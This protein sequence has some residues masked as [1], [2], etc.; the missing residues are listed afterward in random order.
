LTL[1]EQSE[2]CRGKSS[3]GVKKC[4]VVG[5]KNAVAVWD[6]EFLKWGP[7]SIVGGDR[8]KCMQAY[9]RDAEK[10]KIIQE[11]DEEP[12]CQVLIL[13]Y[14]SFKKYIPTMKNYTTTIDLVIC[15][16]AHLLKND[17]TERSKA[18]RGFKPFNKNTVWMGMTGT[19][20]QNSIEEY[21]NLI[22]FFCPGTL[23]D[24]YKQ[25]ICRYECNK[26]FLDIK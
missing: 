17:T 12:K 21:A 8:I 10:A 24:N 16:E 20:Y 2:K 1:L 25:S 22:Q 19:P 18:F 26:I 7:V 4:I 5:P 9:M 6:D 15:D 14:E 11:F 23:P 3:P 13:S